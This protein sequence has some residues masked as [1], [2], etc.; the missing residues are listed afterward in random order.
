MENMIPY[1]SFKNL[2]ALAIVLTLSACQLD[3]TSTPPSTEPSFPDSPSSVENTQTSPSARSRALVDYYKKVQRNLLT[4]GLL[5]TDG[6]GPDVAYSAATLAQNFERIAFFHEYSTSGGRLVARENASHLSRWEKPV[7]VT[8][9]FGDSVPEQK[10]RTDRKVLS[11]Y[12]KR[13]ARV[14]NHP[15]YLVKEG[16]EKRGNF[17]VFVLNEDERRLLGVEIDRFVP[18]ISRP[19]LRAVM[20]MARDTYCLVFARDPKNNGKF[21]QAVA[22]IRSEHPDL[23]RASC[24]HEEVA[25]GL[26]LSNDSPLARPSIFNDDEE[27]AYLTT[28]DEQLLHML[29][30]DRLYSGMTALEARPFIAIMAAELTAG[31]S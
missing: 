15:I 24:L 25:Q 26:G 9:E 18:D 5:R 28:H 17:R 2:K 8:I 6:G 19:N 7:L 1:A 3:A 29:Y 16:D 21:Q 31:A 23:M 10:R 22:V 20:D 4:R 13:L 27:F 14:T 12:V 11:R 30:D